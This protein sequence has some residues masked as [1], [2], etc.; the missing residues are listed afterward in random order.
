MVEIAILDTLPPSYRL[1]LYPSFTPSPFNYPSLPP[2]PPA[3]AVV[4]EQHSNRCVSS[5]YSSI[6]GAVTILIERRRQGGRKGER[7]KKEREGAR[8][9]GREE[10]DLLVVITTKNN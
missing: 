9:E 8:M 10:D 2:S 3:L 1:S 7:G 4:Y 6:Q 5:L